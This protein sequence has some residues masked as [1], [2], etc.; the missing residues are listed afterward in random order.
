LSLVRSASAN[1]CM[2]CLHLLLAA[3]LLDPRMAC[4]AAEE[5]SAPV[6]LHVV[7]ATVGQLLEQDHYT[8]RKLD[9]SVAKEVLETYLE[10]LDYNKLFFTQEDIDQIRN[11]Y[12]SGLND[13]ILLGN[14]TPANNIYAIFRQR[15]DQRLAK[16]S[17]LL[18]RR[19]KF[20][21][22]QTVTANRAKEP[23]PANASVAD[24][25]WRDWIQKELLEEKLS[26]ASTNSGAEMVS[27]RYRDL[28]SEI[29]HE[30][31]VGV[32]RIFLEAVAHTYDAHSDYL[33]P[34]ELNE[35]NIDT[36]LTVSGIGVQIRMEDGY[37]T[38]NRIFPG[39]P[40]DRSG[41]LHVGD[42]I[43]GIAPAVG[44]FVNTVHADMDKFTEMVLG[45]DGS[46]VRLQLSSGK[47][48]DPSKRRVVTLV[49]KE[50]RLT[51]EEAQAQLVERPMA[52]G[53]IEKLGWIT[54]PSFYGKSDD[55][56]TATSVTDDV[57]L[58]L[59][60]LEK[61]GV[62][63][64]VVDL[65]NNAGGSVDE[66]ARM[67]SLFI[68]RGPVAQ[69]KD[70]SGAIHL[71]EGPPGKVL[72]NGPMVVLDNKLT[73]SASEIFSAALQDYGRAVIVG[74]SS[75]FGKGT[76]QTVVELSN[77]LHGTDDSANSSGALKITI[78]KIYRVTGESTQ[79]K[80]VISD[81]VIPSLT[82]SEKFGESQNEHPLAFDE[83]APT[84]I[85]V[86]G[87]HQPLLLD[88]LRSRSI[89]RTNQDPLFH[90]LS[91]EIRQIKEKLSDHSVSL[92]EEVRRKEIA[93]GASL[94]DKADSDRT[95]AAAHDRTKYYRLMLSDLD[96]PEL[97]LINSQEGLAKAGKGAVPEEA[98]YPSNSLLPGERE[99]GTETEKDAIRRETLNILTDLISLKKGPLMATNGGTLPK[100]GDRA[101]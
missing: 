44:P 80:G 96:R 65:R 31:D 23:W 67:S 27:R 10:S 83:V 91:A 82:D 11:E 9:A 98:A 20:D 45:Q 56:S 38:I 22:N 79:L 33:R 37:A 93:E 2:K 8:Q 50:V 62:Q 15:V 99:F 89:K 51:E 18:T 30:D 61:E 81:V 75:S 24:G 72:Y 58:L 88:E 71:L 42:K 55:V 1:C 76:V 43:V 49:R 94:Q 48:E 74:D 3:V 70:P 32:L 41:K 29:D 86:A 17:D 54:V 40:A 35:F 6:D 4:V 39:G 14:L 101:R 26:G 100:G 92:N 64:V 97:K 57:T 87:N 34:S 46:V 47:T 19:Y 36:R 63:G 73:A 21:G 16:V 59:K 66:A 52:G 53:S 5:R 7:E 60:R 28:Q 77:L 12:G 85:D 13:D 90:D 95:S 84:A 25:V 69:L 78:E 68:N